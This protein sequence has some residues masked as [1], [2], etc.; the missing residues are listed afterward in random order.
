VDR[1]TALQLLTSGESGVVQWN[2]WVGDPKGSAGIAD[3]DLTGAELSDAK[4]GGVNLSGAN[5]SA[6]KLDWADLKAADFSGACLHGADLSRADLTGANLSGA[7][8]SEAIFQKCY[9]S[10]ANLS[11]A[12]LLEADLTG[13]DLEAADL[14]GS[15]LRDAD[16]EGSDLSG[17]KL[18]SADLMF[19]NLG[20]IRL[21]DAD[22]TNAICGFTNF[23]NTNLSATAG[24]DS[25][26]HIGPSTIG[27]DTCEL[28]GGKLPEAFL[29][30]CGL[31][32]WQILSVKC[33]DYALTPSQFNDLCSRIFTAWTK[34]RLTLGGCFISYSW[35]DSEF[36]EKL[37]TRLIK[38]G[39]NAW[40]DKHDLVA[41]EIQKQVWRAIQIQQVV[42]LVLSD[43]STKSDWVE[44]E[45]DMARAKEKAEGRTVLCPVSLDDAW[46]TKIEASSGPGDPS[47]PL[48]L[49]LKQKLI[50][51]FSKWKT[52][53]F[54]AQ[55]QKLL[56][57]LQVNYGPAATSG[58]DPA[59]ASGK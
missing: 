48:W 9:L 59:D 25:V 2:N 33:Y 57:G 50:L 1:E 28:S 21:D 15:N 35:N 3:I 39:I 37:R 7:D 41:G 10:G 20:L 14:S 8:L 34:S 4:L 38:E 53:A 56:H 6:A 32:P 22:L 42:I 16:F 44:N 31:S 43:A 46:K 55:F 30:G 24:L 49:T 51:D 52:K 58:T 36:A 18:T 23:G 27:I 45:L 12:N 11:G 5:L 29:R 17:A 47:R 40:L 26:R 54:D 19:A 13:C